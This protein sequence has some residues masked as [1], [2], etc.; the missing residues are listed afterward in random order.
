MV[1]PNHSEVT[2]ENSNEYIL[3]TFLML[4][5]CY[6]NHVRPVMILFHFILEK[7]K[8]VEK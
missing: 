8:S 3:D 5:N 6:R 2:R 4:F 7:I 1:K